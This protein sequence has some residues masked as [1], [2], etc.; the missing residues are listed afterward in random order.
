MKKAVKK[1]KKLSAK[2]SSMK[3]S[4]KV[5]PKKAKKKLP[6]AKKLKQEKPLGI[7]THYFGNIRVAI[8]KFKVPVRQGAEVWF[9]GHTTNFLQ[10]IKSMQFDHKMIL[11]APKGK[12]VGIKVSKKVRPG[13]KVFKNQ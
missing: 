6:V 3:R 1:N 5:A 4:K 12:Q 2:A 11:I 13:D 9:R 8:V 10:A 7:V